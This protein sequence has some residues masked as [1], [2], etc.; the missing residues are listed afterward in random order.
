M[1]DRVLKQSDIEKL[2]NMLKKTLEDT[3]NFPL[4]GKTEI[5]QVQGETR[6]DVFDIQIYRGK[7]NPLKYN[8][9]ALI[10][11]KNIPLLELHIDPG[12]KHINPDGTEIKGTHWHILSEAHG[13][14]V[15][16]AA[17]DID[18]ELFVEN[19]IMFLEKLHVVKKPD[20]HFQPE[21][22]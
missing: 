11:F 10:S 5:F 19:T 9:E 7:I 15:A 18:S 6:K 13:R 20:I 4:P 3:A 21:L 16:Y 22:L 12:N 14:E 8:L 1:P 2:L 17:T